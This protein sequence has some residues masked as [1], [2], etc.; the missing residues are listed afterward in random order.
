MES[1][2]WIFFSFESFRDFLLHQDI[3]IIFK[4]K[5]DFYEIKLKNTN[6]PYEKF[7]FFLKHIKSENNTKAS[8]YRVCVIFYVIIMLG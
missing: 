1:K 8:F 6:F 2:I 3:K 5:F 7:N 4:E